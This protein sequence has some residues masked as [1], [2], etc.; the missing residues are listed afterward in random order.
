MYSVM[1]TVVR[2]LPM[3]GSGLICNMFVGLTVSRIPVVYLAST[4]FPHP[5]FLLHLLTRLPFR[6]YRNGLYRVGFPALRSARSRR[7][8]LGVWVPFCSVGGDGC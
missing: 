6:S 3:A 7:V 1:Q 4:C 5:K 2:F 8:V